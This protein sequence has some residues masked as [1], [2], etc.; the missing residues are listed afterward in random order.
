MSGFDYDRPYVDQAALREFYAVDEE[1]SAI[2]GPVVRAAKL[3][4]VEYKTRHGRLAEQNNMKDPPG[5]GRIFP[6]YLVVR[7]LGT[8]RQYE[9]WMPEEAFEETYSPRRPA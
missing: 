8:T 9:T 6:G 3:A 4:N 2:F 5:C 1:A 7:N